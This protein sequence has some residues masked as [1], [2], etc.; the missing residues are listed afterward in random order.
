VLGRRLLL[1]LA[2]LLGL[3]LV[4]GS[5]APQREAPTRPYPVTPGVPGSNPGPVRKLVLKPGGRVVARV[6]QV[7]NLEVAVKTPDTVEIDALGVSMFAD[8]QTAAQLEF[9]AYPAGTYPVTL[10]DTGQT[11]GTLVIAPVQAPP[12][13]PSGVPDSGAGR[14]S[15]TA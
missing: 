6:G 11:I 13:P 7:V 5:I 9:L 4:V 12:V 15:A 1:W 14:G 3:A 10:H 8:P 2:A